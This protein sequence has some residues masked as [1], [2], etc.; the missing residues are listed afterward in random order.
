MMV[1]RTAKGLLKV[2]EEENN[3][4]RLKDQCTWEEEGQGLYK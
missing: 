1:L 2:Y 3:I 4:L